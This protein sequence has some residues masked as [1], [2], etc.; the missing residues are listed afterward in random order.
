MR[1]IGLDVLVLKMELRAS[2]VLS[3]YSLSLAVFWHTVFLMYPIMAVI[4]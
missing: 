4:S 2:H 1:T 3:N